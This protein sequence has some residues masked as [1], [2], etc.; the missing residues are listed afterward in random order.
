MSLLLISG[1]A[2]WQGVLT[3]FTPRSKAIA[4]IKGALWCGTESGV[5]TGNT[6][7]L[8][9]WYRRV[10]QIAKESDRAFYG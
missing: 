8:P 4:A 2:V 1:T 5:S 6:P 7:I 9:A 10:T 3:G